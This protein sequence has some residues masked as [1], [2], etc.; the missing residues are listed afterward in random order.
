MSDTKRSGVHLHKQTGKWRA[1]INVGGK[2]TSLGLFLTEAEAIAARTEAATKYGISL[3]YTRDQ[4]LGPSDWRYLFTYEHETGR[5]INRVTRPNGAVQGAFADQA[6]DA[7]YRVVT[8]AGRHYR[9]HRVIWEMCV[10]SI[11]MAMEIDH[12]N[13]VR[14]DNRL[15][16]LRLVTSHENHLNLSRRR[17]TKVIHGVCFAKK[18]GKWRANVGFKNRR[19]HIGDFS[20]VSDAIAARQEVNKQLGFKGD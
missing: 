6:S 15:A 16:N 7:G 12:I 20:N 11:P 13:R 8:V 18:E 3:A 9:A 19:I 17:D 5:L 1:T 14:S 2:R 10:G 4:Q